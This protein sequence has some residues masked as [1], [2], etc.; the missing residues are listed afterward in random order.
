MSVSNITNSINPFSTTH[1]A[2]REAF[3]NLTFEQKI[4]TIALTVIAALGTCFLL[5]IGGIATFKA[6][7]D[8]YTDP[9][10][11]AIRRAMATGSLRDAKLLR[12]GAD[13]NDCETSSAGVEKTMLTEAVEIGNREIAKVLLKGGA[14]IH[15][16][17]PDRKTALMIAVKNE[18]IPM[19][20]LLLRHGAK[21]DEKSQ[22]RYGGYGEII[23][24]LAIAKGDLL[25]ILLS[26]VEE[27]SQSN[28]LVSA[29]SDAIMNYCQGNAGID[30]IP[31][32]LSRKEIVLADAEE[33][34]D[35][36]CNI[37]RFVPKYENKLYEVRTC[38]R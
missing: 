10:D 16:K 20:K 5:G 12:V 17:D 32:L 11:M 3:K 13:I 1:A 7:V 26:F 23:N 28:L 27:S 33:A 18:D 6:C 2:A 25:N 38:F 30:Q 4:K 22:S 24:V 19:V 31:I 36:I 15:F 35:D 37:Y 9:L 21:V 14:N 8:R 34:L 29:L